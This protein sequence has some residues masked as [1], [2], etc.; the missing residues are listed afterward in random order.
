MNS[1]AVKNQNLKQHFNFNQDQTCFEC[2]DCIM[3]ATDITLA[4]RVKLN[5]TEPK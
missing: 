5:I 1:C 3:H 2:I 4:G